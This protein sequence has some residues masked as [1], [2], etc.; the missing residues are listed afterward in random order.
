MTI[1]GAEWEGVGEAYLSDNAGENH[2]ASAITREGRWRG[3]G[4]RG[5]EGYLQNPLREG[6]DRHL[7][8]PDAAA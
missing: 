1:K 5:R 6:R 4:G 8:G 2:V 7:G 3:S